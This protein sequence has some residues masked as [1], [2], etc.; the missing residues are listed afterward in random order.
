MIDPPG[1]SLL[2]IIKF[3]NET[4]VNKGREDGEASSDTPDLSM[5]SGCLSGSAVIF[6]L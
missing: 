1:L 2:S 5:S 4:R 3:G 6:F